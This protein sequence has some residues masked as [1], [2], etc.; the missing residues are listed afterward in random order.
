MM[1]PAVTNVP[2][3]SAHAAATLIST[4]TNVRMFGW[5]RSATH[6]LMMSWSGN[7]QMR[8]MSPVKVIE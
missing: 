5:I 3:P 1:K 2:S 6:V 4:P 8:P 7:R